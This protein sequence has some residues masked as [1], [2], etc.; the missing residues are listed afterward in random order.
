MLG[1][2][3]TSAVGSVGDDPPQFSQTGVQGTLPG[4]NLS[5][6]LLNHAG[7]TSSAMGSSQTASAM[8]SVGVN[9][10]GP[11]QPGSQGS[12]PGMISPPGHAVN[13]PSVVPRSQTAGIGGYG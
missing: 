9:L 2:Q 7:T 3:K 10:T 13:L 4:S 8:W 1:S 12:V 5:T 11:S 6:N